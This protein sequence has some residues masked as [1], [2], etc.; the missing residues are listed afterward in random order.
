[1]MKKR[2]WAYLDPRTILNDDTCLVMTTDASDSAIAITLFRV[3]KANAATVT[4]EDLLDPTLTQNVG[5]CY[6]KL[7]KAER[8][9]NTFETE[10]YAII[11]GFKKFGSYITTAIVRYPTTGV[12]ALWL[13]LGQY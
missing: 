7:T 9:W 11:T 4:K 5:V 1:M 8:V 12:P 6:K 3:K 10:L 13:I 2:E